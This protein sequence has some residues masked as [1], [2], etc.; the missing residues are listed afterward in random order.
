MWVWQIG[1]DPGGYSEG[2]DPLFGAWASSNPLG[3]N[4]YSIEPLDGMLMTG[5]DDFKAAVKENL[6]RRVGSRCSN[7]GCRRLTV[8]PQAVEAGAA[9]IG[10]AAHLTAAASG[11]PRYDSSLT[12]EQRASQDNG[13]WLCRTCSRL[14]DVDA[15]GYPLGRLQKWKLE[16]E[17]IAFRECTTGRIVVPRALL[18][19][20]EDEHGVP[21]VEFMAGGAA[22]DVATLLPRML[23]AAQ[24]DLAGFGRILGVPALT[25]GLTLTL[26]DIGGRR[27]LTPVEV[28][29]GSQLAAAVCVVA[30]PG[31]GK[32][33]TLMQIAEAILAE[34]QDAALFI[35]M[36]EWA[37]TAGGFFESV[38][39]RAGFA[40]FEVA[41][42]R[43]V[44]ASGRR[45]LILDAWNELDGPS[46]ARAIAELTR[47]RR[48][49]PLLRVV[50]STRRQA[51]DVPGLDAVVSLQGLSSQQQ[52]ELAREIA[53]LAGERQLEAAQR[54]RFA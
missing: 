22:V 21:L 28:A 19:L 24:A 15:T 51:L 7:P 31:A 45:V 48:E 36:A 54:A 52:R 5:R 18:P 23:A 10:V 30:P 14:I 43:A 53:G 35:P 12:S 20:A 2:W 40:G 33:V 47:L 41:A 42:F 11:G 39:A 46:R 1:L 13:I 9:N 49:L 34:G 4:I 29:R 3:L 17:A 6:W 38:V 25:V 37:A 32:T 44:A 26:E 8:G 27:S 16:A 50:A